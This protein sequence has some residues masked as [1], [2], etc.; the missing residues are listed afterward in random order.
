MAG[1]TKLD[2]QTCYQM[3]QAEGSGGVEAAQQLP[4]DGNKTYTGPDM[5]VM[6]GMGRVD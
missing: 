2:G 6:Y 3:A 1:H 4:D 5:V